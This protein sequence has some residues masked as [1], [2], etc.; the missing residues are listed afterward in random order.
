MSIDYKINVINAEDYIY[1]QYLFNIDNIGEVELLCK[2]EIK[3][4]LDFKIY[5]YKEPNED[6]AMFVSSVVGD[7]YDYKIILKL[8][9]NIYKKVHVASNKRLLKSYNISILNNREVIINE[10]K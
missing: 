5:K 10:A 7:L 6:I 3:T 4:P 2:N 9:V 1:N 8:N